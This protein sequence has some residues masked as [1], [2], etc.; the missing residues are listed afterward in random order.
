[1]HICYMFR[2]SWIIQQ[3][4]QAEPQKGNNRHLIGKRRSILYRTQYNIHNNFTTVPYTEHNTT[5]TTT[6]PPYSI[7]NTIQHTQQLYHCTLCR[8]QYNIH[9]NFTTVPYAEHNTTYTVT[10]P[11]YP[12]QNTI[13]HT[14]QLYHC[15][16]FRTQYNILNDFPTVTHG[17]KK[18]NIYHLHAENR[19][20]ICAHNN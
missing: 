10:L 18:W 15:T 6:L 3:L 2:F 17:I 14:Q 13:Q 12:M 20:V 8:T 16:L 5:Y 4:V 7:Q 9:N 11:P 1:M 19:H